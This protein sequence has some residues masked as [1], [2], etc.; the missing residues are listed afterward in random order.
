MSID[1]AR[2]LTVDQRGGSIVIAAL[3]LLTTVSIGQLW[4]VVC[5]AVHQVR[6]SGSPQSGL[7]QQ[8]QAV[9]RNS[10][11]SARVLVLLIKVAWAWKDKR[12]NAMRGSLPLIALAALHLVVLAVST[13]LSSQI[14]VTG[15]EVLLNAGVCGWPNGVDSAS[16]LSSEMNAAEQLDATLALFIQGRQLGIQGQRYAQ[17]CYA[18]ESVETEPAI[19]RNYVASRIPMTSSSVPCPFSE[20]ICALPDAAQIDT[21]H[22]DSN[23]HLGINTGPESRLRLRKVLTCAPLLAEQRFSSNWTTGSSPAALPGESYRLYFLGRTSNNNYTWR[24]RNSTFSSATGRN[25]PYILE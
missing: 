14:V 12:I 1:G 20:E 24:V 17:L 4:S 6:S 5:F 10:S 21:G 2:V 9:L 16:K 15:D 11:T 8:Q 22:I 23:V 3:A 25:A 18:N 19:C 13:V 7:H